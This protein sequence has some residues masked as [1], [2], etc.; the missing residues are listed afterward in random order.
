MQMG[1][2]NG[3]TGVTVP[4]PRWDKGRDE[5][6]RPARPWQRLLRE[7]VRDPVELLRLLGLDAQAAR[8]SASAAAQ[9]P[10]RVPRG[11][12]ARMRHGD[13]HDPLLRQVLPIVD[14]E[15]IELGDSADA[16]GDLAART[17]PGVLVKYHGRALLIATGSCAVHCRYCFRRH[18][19]YGAQTAAADGWRAALG[20]LAGQQS[21]TEV[22]LS[23][24]D[25]LALATRKLTALTDALAKL[26][27]I[28]RVRLHTRLPIVLPERIDEELLDW[29]TGL[30]RPLVVV[31]HANHPN[32]IDD[33]VC[34]ALRA[35]GAAGAVLLNQAV[36][37]RGV[38]D[39]AGCQ[40][41]LSERLFEAGVL[42][43]YLH[44]LDRVAG[45]AHFAVPDA[46]AQQI[47][48]ALLARL[49]GYLV[50]RLVRE[51][52]GAPAKVPLP[53]SGAGAAPEALRA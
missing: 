8:L 6:A 22:V 27:H 45:A 46:Q 16:V 43:Y 4:G 44:Q 23:G 24:G 1:G 39:D 36:L 34:R 11:F 10:L 15:R 32:E 29:V 12:I 48:A 52:A 53:G 50:P 13:P 38:N 18:F 20:Y 26:A 3:D 19:P 47:H 25:P 14:E 33:T 42:P 49:P 40:A 51:Q 30:A 35:L 17:V 37:L 21:I 5:P 2:S 41:K 28:R 7:A 31:V 9:F